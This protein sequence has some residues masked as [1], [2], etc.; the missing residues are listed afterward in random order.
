MAM[1]A[2]FAETP[3]ACDATLA[4]AES[5]DLRLRFGEDPA[6]RLDQASLGGPPEL[7]MRL[8]GVV[9][10]IEH[11]AGAPL[12]AVAAVEHQAYVAAAPRAKRLVAPHGGRRQI[13]IVPAHL[14]REV[15]HRDL[16]AARHRDRPRPHQ[17]RHPRPLL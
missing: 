12:V 2:L 5:V 9:A 16:A 14:F 10:D 7:Q 11:V 6:R 4:I 13:G 1:R 15:G 3:E 17:G 8:Q